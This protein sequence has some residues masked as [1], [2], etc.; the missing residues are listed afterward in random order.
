M[1]MSAYI[2]EHDT[3]HA[4]HTVSHAH[5]YACQHECAHIKHTNS[6]RARSERAD[7]HP[8][9]RPC[10]TLPKDAASSADHP[11][12]VVSRISVPSMS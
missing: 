11:T 5:A 1:C 7:E 6:E 2:Q 10:H 4:E 9:L 8:P 3:T 12:K